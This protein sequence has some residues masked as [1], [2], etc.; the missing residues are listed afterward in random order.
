M[1]QVNAVLADRPE[2]PWDQALLLIADAEV[3]Y[4]K[5][6][7][8]NAKESPGDNR[9]REERLADYLNGETD[10]FDEFEE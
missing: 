2:L 1:E 4:E 6:K 9:A 10:D 7:K 3:L 8:S 5:L